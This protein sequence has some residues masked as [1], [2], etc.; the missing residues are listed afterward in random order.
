MK[1]KQAHRHVERSR[2]ERKSLEH[3]SALTIQRIFRGY[4]VRIFRK[5]VQILNVFTRALRSISLIQ[6]YRHRF[7]KR[8]AASIIIQRNV[9]SM[10]ARSVARAVRRIRIAVLRIQRIGRAFCTRR[11]NAVRWVERRLVERPL[12]ATV[13]PSLYEIHH[14]PATAL[15]R[16]RFLPKPSSAT[17]CNRLLTVVSEERERSTL[18]IEEEAKSTKRLIW[19]ANRLHRRGEIYQFLSGIQHEEMVHRTYVTRCESEEWEPLIAEFVEESKPF[20][21]RLKWLSK[22]FS[23]QYKQMQKWSNDVVN[24]H[25]SNLMLAATHLRHSR[26]VSASSAMIRSSSN[27]NS[28]SDERPMEVRCYFA[29]MRYLS[30]ISWLRNRGSAD[31]NPPIV[32]PPLGYTAVQ[33]FIVQCNNLAASC[34]RDGD[35][36]GALQYF[37]QVA[38][39]EEEQSLWLL[40]GRSMS[41]PIT[42]INLCVV[43]TKLRECSTAVD[44]ARTAIH[45]LHEEV[46]KDFNCLQSKQSNP[47]ILHIISRERLQECVVT[48]YHN[49]HVALL[50]ITGHQ[51][52]LAESMQR[53]GEMSARLALACKKDIY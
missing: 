21:Q 29:L 36:R 39:A 33:Q 27:T 12:S 16:P 3:F 18:L 10:Q 8:T 45:I 52:E 49:L 5:R 31:A 40:N 17:F 43:Y 6:I 23:H 2:E 9:R 4:R 38:R 24:A 37:R 22:G 46:Q 44:L 42:F 51:P 26:P 13:Q 15:S 25:Q 1:R 35:Y 11:H 28:M 30:L 20:Q 47:R 48:S 41:S 34:S 53:V 7:Q 32:I 19:S 50:G 14:R